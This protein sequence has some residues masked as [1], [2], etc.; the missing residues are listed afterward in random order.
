MAVS[1]FWVP[2]FGG[3]QEIPQ[4]KQQTFLFFLL[5]GSPKK[6]ERERER[7]DEIDSGALENVNRLATNELQ[8]RSWWVLAAL[9]LTN[10]EG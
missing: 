4:G 10:F 7:P 9:G 3:S 8:L 5:G 2:I 6:G 1:F